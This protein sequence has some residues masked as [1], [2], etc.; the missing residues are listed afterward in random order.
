MVKEGDLNTVKVLVEEIIESL[1]QQLS[2]DKGISIEESLDIIYNSMIYRLLCD[3]DTNLY[4]EGFPY[5][6]EILNNEIQ[7]EL[8]K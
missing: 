7:E 4:S 2:K 8:S 6:Y 3:E 5:V 1:V